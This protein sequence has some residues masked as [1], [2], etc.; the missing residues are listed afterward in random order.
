MAHLQVI[1]VNRSEEK[2]N[3]DH[4]PLDLVKLTIQ[5]IGRLPFL[6]KHSTKIDAENSS[7]VDYQMHKY[8]Y[9]D[10]LHYIS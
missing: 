7:V 9:L 4:H 1:Q 2:L 3:I 10:Y 5:L 6:H 8:D